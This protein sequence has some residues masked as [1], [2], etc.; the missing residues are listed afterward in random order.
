LFDFPG[1]YDVSHQVKSFA[2]VVFEEVVEFA[3]LAILGAKMY[4]ADE[5]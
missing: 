1:I 5:N 2:G 3:S 4:I